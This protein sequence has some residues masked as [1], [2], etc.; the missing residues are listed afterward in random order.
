MFHNPYLA[1]ALARERH[2]QLLTE[3]RAWRQVREAHTPNRSL[4]ARLAR[5]V[6]W[7]RFSSPKNPLSLSSDRAY[8]CPVPGRVP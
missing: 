2:N 4:A 7:V 1:A 6:R 5:S 8:Q 3:A